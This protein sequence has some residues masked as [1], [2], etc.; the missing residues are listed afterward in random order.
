MT[1]VILAAGLGSRYGG[2]KQLDPLGAHGE[3]II[4]YS[5]YDAAF[6]GYDKIVFVIKRENYA[7]FRETIGARAEKRAAVE[8]VF[9]EPELYCDIPFPEGRKKPWGTGHA[10]LCVKGHVRDPFA[11]INA[12]DFYGRGSF[13][14]VREYLERHPADGREHFCMAG[15]VLRN[16][17]SDEGSVSR[18][19]CRVDENGY[20][21]SVTEHKKL[22]RDGA[23]ARSEGEDGSLCRISGDT[24]VSMNFYGLTPALL[25]RMEADFSRFLRTPGLDLTRAEFG[26]T[27][28]VSHAVE[29][30]FADLAVLPTPESWFGVTYAADKPLV[31]AKIAALHTRGLYPPTLI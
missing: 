22:T 14:L 1:L 3:F 21:L 23:D 13:S 15:Y 7:L 11:V 4:D 31:K 26:L 12:D 17:L 8:Y 18:G 2:L 10:L 27:D 5:V 19:I 29:E 9:Q 24:L 6:C 20:L 30:G 28:A 25:E 16:T